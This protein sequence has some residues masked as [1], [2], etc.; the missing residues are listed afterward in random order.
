MTQ[1]QVGSLVRQM[2]LAIGGA[3]VTKGYIDSDTMVAVV[4]I[5][6]TVLTGA[7]GIYIR[8]RDGLIASAAAQPGVEHVLVKPGVEMSSSALMNNSKVISK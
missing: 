4:G 1:E 6:V 5:V 3:A 7:Y 2:L 8:R